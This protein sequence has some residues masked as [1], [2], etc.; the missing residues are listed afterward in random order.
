MEREKDLEQMVN[1][2]DYLASFWNA[3][4]VMKIKEIR[5]QQESERFMTDEQFEDMIESRGFEDSDLVKSIIESN[6]DLHANYKA[7]SM[8]NDITGN[9]Y[10]RMPSDLSDLSGYIK[11]KD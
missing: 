1:I 7:Q 4:A 9:R 5:E 6:K 11:D 2:A 3:E 10:K 8:G